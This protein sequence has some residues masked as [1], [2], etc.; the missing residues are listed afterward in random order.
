MSARGHRSEPKGA[1]GAPS[2]AAL[3]A[4]LATISRRARA[5]LRERSAFRAAVGALDGAAFLAGVPALLEIAAR[6][7]A[8]V[9]LFGPGWLE[10]ATILVPVAWIGARAAPRAVAAIDD[11]FALAA[12]DRALGLGDRLIAARDFLR[13]P[14]PSGFMTAAIEDARGAATL[15]LASGLPPS[16]RPHAGRSPLLRAAG[17][18]LLVVA[19][20]GIDLPP[21]RPIPPPTELGIFAGPPMADRTDER[22]EESLRPLPPVPPAERAPRAEERRGAD[23]EPAGERSGEL[24]DDAKETLGRTASGR[25]AAAASASGTSRSKGTPSSRTQSGESS[26]ERAAD[27]P[28]KPRE[29]VAAAAEPP[30]PREPEEP[31]GATAGRGAAGGSGKSPAPSPWSSKDQVA[32]EEEREIEPEEA[33]ED[34]FE[35][36]EARG[37]VQPQLRDRKP[38]VNRDLTIGYGNRRDPDANGRGGASEQKKSRGVASL[39]LGVPIPDPISGRPNPGRTKVTQERVEPEEEE[40]GKIE[41]EARAPREAPIGPVASPDLEPWLRNLVKEYF[42]AIRK[43]GTEESE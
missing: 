41:A 21:P 34:E 43:D 14:A 40:A 23:D 17:A 33:P 1:G 38:P 36:S 22:D 11:A 32:S 42:R 25:S 10:A 30:A 20:L 9:R 39:V 3:S 18:L 16:A 31:S 35:D 12:V 24:T 2:T 27:T 29:P 6:L 8:G 5:T 26:P 4:E 37:G 15:A 7:L 19:A 13:R 28:R